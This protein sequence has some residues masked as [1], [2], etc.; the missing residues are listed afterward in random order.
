LKPFDAKQFKKAFFEEDL[1]RLGSGEW[2]SFWGFRLSLFPRRRLLA[3][4][5]EASAA[6]M[7]GD[8]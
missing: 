8:V 5:W 7:R 1:E 2:E 6:T 3:L 4:A